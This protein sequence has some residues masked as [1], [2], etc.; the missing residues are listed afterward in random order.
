MLSYIDAVADDDVDVVVD[1]DASFEFLSDAR[2]EG[3]SSI[4]LTRLERTK[5]DVI[6]GFDSS[7]FV[8]PFSSELSFS[9]EFEFGAKTEFEFCAGI[10]V[11]KIL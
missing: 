3:S 9:L 6:G 5:Q 1:V 10:M 4:G 7:F 8:D 11:V 2:I